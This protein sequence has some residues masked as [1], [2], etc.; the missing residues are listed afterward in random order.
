MHESTNLSLHVCLVARILKGTSQIH[1]IV[2]FHKSILVGFQTIVSLYFLCGVA[3]SLGKLF[4]VDG[5]VF[6]STYF[7]KH[8]DRK[9]VKQF[10]AHT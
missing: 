4:T 1:G 7:E 8:A 9:D 2:E 5:V 6:I 3:E 10:F